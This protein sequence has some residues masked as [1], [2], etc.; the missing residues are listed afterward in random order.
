[1]DSGLLTTVTT[2]I[3]RLLGKAPELPSPP[4]VIRWSDLTLKPDPDGK[5]C[6]L[7]I[8]GI[9]LPAMVRSQDFNTDS[10]DGSLDIGHALVYTFNKEFIAEWSHVGA[11]ITFVK[12]EYGRLHQIVEESVDEEGWYCVTKGLN[13]GYNDPWKIRLENVTAYVYIVL[14]TE[15]E[16]GRFIYLPLVS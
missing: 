1:M 10:M 4:N 13:C 6:S 14:W 5:T 8:R 7:V 12:G 2:F 15:Q 16:Q 9:P 11:W 3:L